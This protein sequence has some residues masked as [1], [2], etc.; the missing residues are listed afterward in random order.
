M[1]FTNITIH[2]YQGLKGSGKKEEEARKLVKRMHIR[3]T[4]GRSNVGLN[5]G[6]NDNPCNRNEKKSVGNMKR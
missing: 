5:K 2:Q 4:L 6:S 1:H 3:K